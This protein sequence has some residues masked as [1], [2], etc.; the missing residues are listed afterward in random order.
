LCYYRQNNEK[1]KVNNKIK[2]SVLISTTKNKKL[3]IF[4][5]PR[6]TPRDITC[7]V[8]GPTAYFIN[9]KFIYIYKVEASP[10]KAWRDP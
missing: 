5:I 1:P 9:L 7:S 4:V 8:C 6:N 10:V 3:I 2:I